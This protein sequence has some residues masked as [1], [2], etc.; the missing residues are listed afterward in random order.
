M[1]RKNNI[2]YTYEITDNETGVTIIIPT[3]KKLEQYTGYGIAFIAKLVMDVINEPVKLKDDFTVV[4]RL[5][6]KGDI[7]NPFEAKPKRFPTKQK[8]D[9][10]VLFLEEDGIY[11]YITT[12]KRLVKSRRTMAKNGGDIVHHLPITS[13]DYERFDVEALFEEKITKWRRKFYGGK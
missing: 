9:Y 2:V 6:R 8:I 12:Q 13:K 11:Y 1:R 10:E 5:R 3:L 7:F 4:K